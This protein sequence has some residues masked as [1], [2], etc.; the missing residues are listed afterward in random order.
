LTF[1]TKF[2][3]FYSNK[4]FETADQPIMSLYDITSKVKYLVA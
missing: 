3:G 2:N 1:R 4:I